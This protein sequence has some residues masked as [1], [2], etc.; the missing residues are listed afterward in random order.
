MKDNTHIIGAN[1]TNGRS[2]RDFYPTPPECTQALINYLKLPKNVCIWECASGN[3]DMAK[4]FKENGYTCIETDI[5][6][7]KDFLTTNNIA[8]DW[9]ITN[10]PFNISEKFI[11]RAM[12]LNKSFAFLL[13][14]QYW[15]SRKRLKIFRLSQPTHVLPL[16]WRPDFTGAGNSLLDMIW[17]VWDHN[18][19]G[20][21]IY[22]PLEKPQINS[23][24]YKE[25]IER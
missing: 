12:T 3:G 17:V 15:H 5:K 11:L 25:V 9:I 7:G 22:E 18:K 2:E 4:V 6:D 1:P 13:K 14:S 20:A 19:N 10:P 23:F 8:C 16:T 21:T 24:L